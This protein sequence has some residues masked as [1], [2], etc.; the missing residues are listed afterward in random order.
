MDIFDVRA[1]ETTLDQSCRAR[2]RCRKERLERL[3]KEFNRS[4]TERGDFA[5]SQR[6]EKV[7]DIADAVLAHSAGAAACSDI[8]EFRDRMMSDHYGRLVIYTDGQHTCKSPITSKRFPPN[9]RVLVV[10]LPLTGE[11]TGSAFAARTEL[12]KKIFVGDGV[13][14][15]PS[16]SLTEKDIVK[17]L[18]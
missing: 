12:L 5:N 7:T 16:V 2:L 10:Q 18:Q 9:R 13:N 3:E 6:K 17:I 4:K 15:V 1:A 14:I 8:I 11:K